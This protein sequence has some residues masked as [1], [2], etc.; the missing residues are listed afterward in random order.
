MYA[1]IDNH[2]KQVRVSTG[3]TI[4][5]DH[6]DAE[7]GAEITFDRV[8]LVGADD[9]KVGKPI[10]EGASVKAKVVAQERGPKVIAFKFRRRQRSHTR[11]GFRATITKLEILEIVA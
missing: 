11:R 3:E 1:I 6:I 10:V 7:V 4:E 2:G 5:V 8:L 9:V